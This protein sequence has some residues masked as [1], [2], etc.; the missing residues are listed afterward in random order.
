MASTVFKEA[1]RKFLS[2]QNKYKGLM[3]S[4]FL[5]V[6]DYLTSLSCSDKDEIDITVE[7]I[8]IAYDFYLESKSY[9]FGVLF[10]GLLNK[11]N[12]SFNVKKDIYFRITKYCYDDFKTDNS[13]L[14]LTLSNPEL[15]KIV[16]QY[17]M[18]LIKKNKFD[19]CFLLI[20]ELDEKCISYLADETINYIF[21]SG[22]LLNNH[23]S[24]REKNSSLISEMIK[25]K[26][27]SNLKLF[28]TK[29]FYVI[30]YEQ[31]KSALEYSTEANNKSLSKS[32]LIKMIKHFYVDIKYICMVFYMLSDQEKEKGKNF[33]YKV[34]DY[35][36]CR[37][38]IDFLYGN[39]KQASYLD[40]LNINEFIYLHDSIIMQFKDEYLKHMIFVI[41]KAIDENLIDEVFTCLSLYNENI[42]EILLLPKLQKA[43]FKNDKTRRE[44]LK[45]VIEHNMLKQIGLK[46]YVI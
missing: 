18:D 37:Y 3:Q 19:N 34:G 20:D 28:F 31:I 8:M 26:M 6:S 15:S 41:N 27:D 42:E 24:R 44:Y 30:S 36:N 2:Y 29:H 1:Q 32:I 39:K 35:N 14:Q 23:V 33:F 25:R 9:S 7:A 22:F 12:Y 40:Y 17:I 16:N 4:Y 45:L 13:F 46:E 5:C 11:L 43:S 10:N 38:L 21:E